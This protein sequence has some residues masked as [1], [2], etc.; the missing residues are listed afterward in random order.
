MKQSKNCDVS[1]YLALIFLYCI[2]LDILYY[3]RYMF[4]TDV[5]GP[6]GTHK[7]F[8]ARMDG[9][10]MITLVE[11]LSNPTSKFQG[12]SLVKYS[13]ILNNQSGLT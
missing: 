3:F 4:F 9:S 5:D 7:I 13:M 8:R 10:E 2:I 6:V 12:Y 11:G 1:S